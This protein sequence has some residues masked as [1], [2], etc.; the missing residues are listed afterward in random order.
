TRPKVVAG[1]S[2]TGSPKKAGRNSPPSGNSGTQLTAHYGESG[3]GSVSYDDLRRSTARRPERLNIAFIGVGS[4]GL[5]VM[6]HFLREPDVQ[7]IAVCD[8]NNSSAN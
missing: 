7:G 1:G 3:C 5:R 6:L 8:P 4:Q 2:T